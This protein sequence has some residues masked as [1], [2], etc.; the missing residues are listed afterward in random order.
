MGIKSAYRQKSENKSEPAPTPVVVTPEVAKGEP[1]SV[2]VRVHAGN[3]DDAS[4]RLQTQIAALEQ[5]A[6]IQ[7]DPREAKLAFWK[8][9]DMSPEDERFL[10][11][12]PVLIDHDKL[13]SQVSHEAAKHHPPGTDEHRQAVKALFNHLMGDAER[14]LLA[15]AAARRPMPAPQMINTPPHVQV[16]HNGGHAMSNDYSDPPERRV[17][18]APVSREGR[19]GGSYGGPSGK[20]TLTQEERNFAHQLGLSETEYAKQKLKMHHDYF[21]TRGREREDQR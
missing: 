3:N 1:P 10:R 8:Q 7:H 16:S 4:Q 6:R 2:V 12:N 21:P 20:V 13:T 9:Q 11:E 15:K 17:V 14:E 5:A 18:S 19:S